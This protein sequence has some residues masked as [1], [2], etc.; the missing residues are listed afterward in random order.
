[1]AIEMCLCYQ[2]GHSWQHKLL[3]KVTQ[4]WRGW[5][6]QSGILLFAGLAFSKAMILS[7]PCASWTKQLKS[8]TKRPA[9]PLDHLLGFL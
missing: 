1:M 5:K 6:E 4:L 2:A 3:L 8:V 9:S 7:K